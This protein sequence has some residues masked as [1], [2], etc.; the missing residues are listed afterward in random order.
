MGQHKIAV[1]SGSPSGYDIGGTTV[2]VKKKSCA[3]CR[4]L[5]WTLFAALVLV[6]EALLIFFLIPRDP[7]IS[8]KSA[9]TSITSFSAAPTPS[10]V[11]TMSIIMEVYNPS[12]VQVGF[13]DLDL[14]MYYAADGTQM[15]TVQAPMGINVPGRGSQ[16]LTINVNMDSS[17]SPAW[18]PCGSDMALKSRC[19]VKFEGTVRPRYM[20]YTLP[21]VAVSFQQ[22]L[23][24]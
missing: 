18:A 2:V 12:Y 3:S 14:K 20:G 13:A 21:E 8:N 4:C 17:Q 11:A 16:D 10:F 7:C 23:T 15:G 9:S 6:G 19:L 1:V 24:R 5:L 22:Y